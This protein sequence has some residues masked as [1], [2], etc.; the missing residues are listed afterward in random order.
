MTVGD[1]AF[2]ARAER[3]RSEHEARARAEL[4]HASSLA[5]GSDAGASSGALIAEVA[6]VKGLAGP[7]EAS[8]GAALSGPDGEAAEKALAALGWP[9]DAVFR[10]LSRPEPD[11]PVDT[12]VARLRA[13]LE[14]VDPLVVVALDAAAAEDLALAFGTS[15][16]SP[17]KAVIAAGR[18][19]VAVDDFEASLGD[20]RRK[21]RAWEQLQAARP[22]GPV[23]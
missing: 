22:D 2:T 12:R 15:V 3:I 21:R 10:M 4:A 20:E 18:R 17:G 9:T 6:L 14:A 5:P 13:Q 23:Y 8:G 1:P 19:L 11:T 7:A 16:V